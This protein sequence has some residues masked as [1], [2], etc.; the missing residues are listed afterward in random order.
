MRRQLRRLGL[1]HDSRREIA[2]TDVSF[3]RWTQW[4]FLQIFNSW[5]DDRTGT[6]PADRD[7]IAEFESGQRP[8]PGGLSW[9]Q[10]PELERRAVIDGYRLAYISRR[11]WST[12]AP[13]LG[14]VLANEE[15]TA[16]GRSDIGN[17]PGLPEAAAAVDAADHR[18]RRRLI[19]DLDGW[20]G[21]SRSSSCSATGSA[22]ATAALIDLA[23]WRDSGR[24][25]RRSRCSPRG[26]TPWPAQPMWCSRRS[27]R[28]STGC[29]GVLAG[30]NADRVDVP[31]G[32][33]A[34]E[35][36]ASADGELGAAARWTPQAA[37]AAYRAA[38][39]RLSD[40][41]RTDRRRGQDRRVHRRL[42][43]LTRR[44]GEPIPVFVAD[45]V[46]MG[47]GT[48][49]IMAVPA[50]DQRDLDF[51]GVRAAGPD[52]D[53]RR[54]ADVHR[55]GCGRM[56]RGG[57]MHRGRLIAWLE[58]TRARSRGASADLPA[59]GLA[60]LPAAVLGR[61]VPDRLRRARPAGRAPETLLPV[62]CL[63]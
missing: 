21:R 59:A 10:L 8:A 44:T 27:I 58:R 62:G 18:L 22:P 32:R 24:R 7:L 54:L 28:W 16:D 12:G 26:R 11:N 51:A 40:R 3:Y 20:T 15:V 49:A 42:T 4:I 29:A 6:G 17:Y 34:A 45:Y 31:G 35:V 61:A 52:R 60:V 14:T 46:L 39:A 48:G 41:Q 53:R 25:L 33:D 19:A 43:P 36:A 2:T 30:R 38:A 50:H 63:R 55:L 37:V 1:G 5:V 56:S 9:G 23:R 13:G 57:D 47:Y